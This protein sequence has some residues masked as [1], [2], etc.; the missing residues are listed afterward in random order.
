MQEAM[1]SAAQSA[2]QPTPQ[3]AAQSAA[4]SAAQ[5]DDGSATVALGALLHQYELD[6]VLLAGVVENVAHR[7]VRWVHS[8]ELEDPTPFL[9]RHTVILTTGARLAYDDS[10]S[11]AD[12]YVQRLLDSGAAALG[13]AVGLHWDRVP[14]TYISACDRLGLPLFRVP[15]STPF[16]SIVQTVARLLDA[17]AHAR[18]AW[19][20]ESQRT[21]TNASLHRDGLGAAVRVAATRLGRWVAITNRAGTI[22]EFAP[23]SSRKLVNA[24]AVRQETRQLIDRGVR[25]GRIGSSGKSGMQLR[26]LGR[27]R[28]VLGVLVVEDAGPPDLAERSLLGLVEA[29]ATVQLEHRTGLESAE[30]TLRTSIIELVVAGQLALA[31]RVSAGV[32][33]RIPRDP[34]HVIRYDTP[35]APPTTFV[36]DLLSFDAGSPGL[37]RADIE[38]GPLILTEARHLATVQGLFEVHGVAAGISSRGTLSEVAHLLDQAEHAICRSRLSPVAGPVTYHPELHAGVW[39]LI[40]HHD[41]ARQRAAG[42]LDPLRT[43][44]R[45]HDDHIEASLRVWLAHNGLTSPA[46]AQLGVHRHT[47]KARVQIAESLLERDID[48]PD[49]RSELWAAMRISGRTTPDAR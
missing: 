9:T 14:L 17:E 1:Q 33:S 30:A 16:I 34:L 20:L 28:Q 27:R 24:D 3:L 10:Q 40:E 39:G 42:L 41:E 49:T 47:L 45:K 44:D 48:S 25:A 32:V 4:Q 5:R 2:P 13:I 43:H 21:V 36:D 19:L 37:I 15:Y 38:C 35:T 8:S 31:E 46:A 7:P 11:A 22:I 26:A 18:D 29:L 12:A 23:Q 6:L